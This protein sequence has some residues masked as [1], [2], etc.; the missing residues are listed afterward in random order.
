MIFKVSVSS[1]ST[2]FQEAIL[3]GHWEFWALV[4]S[5]VHWWPWASLFHILGLGFPSVSRGVCKLLTW[6]DWA[7][8]PALKTTSTPWILQLFF[9]FFLLHRVLVIASGI[10]H[11]SSS[12]QYRL[13]SSSGSRPLEYTGSAV[14][15][16]R[17]SCPEVCGIWVLQPE[18]E[19]T[20]PALEGKF[21][22]TRPPG[23]YPSPSS[24]LKLTKAKEIRYT[25]TRGTCYKLF[26][27]NEVYVL[28]WMAVT[29]IRNPRQM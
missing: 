8:L 25:L 10:F 5:L 13:L 19:P 12:L 14:V 15:A 16:R 23:K 9:F 2:C 18:I 17:F 21:S 28:M 26:F 1:V 29:D 24:S 22:T 7:K 11:Y 4:P 20:S 27:W 3:A 6:T